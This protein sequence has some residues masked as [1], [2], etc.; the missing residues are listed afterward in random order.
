VVFEGLPPAMRRA[1]YRGAAAF[2]AV[3]VVG[4]ALVAGLQA[5]A[6]GGEATPAPPPTSSPNPSGEPPE[7]AKTPEA[8]LAWVPGGMPEGFAESLTQAPEVAS[9]TVAGADNVWMRRSFDD[10]GEVVDRPPAG[11][12]IPIDATA[13]DPRPFAAFLPQDM[14]PVVLELDELE[15]VLSE[16]SA[17]LRGLGEGGKLEFRRGITVRVSG[18]LPDALMG[19]YELMVGRST[20][21]K[22]GIRH[23]RYAVFLTSEDAP[24]K[25][26][27]LERA[28]RRLIPPGSTYR[29]VEVRA[30]GTTRF[31]RMSDALL[32]P[33][34]LKDRFGEFAARPDAG[35]PGFL[36]VDPGWVNR[37]IKEITVPLLGSIKCHRRFVPLVRGAM[38]ELVRQ[39]LEEL[40]RSYDGCYAARHTLG[41]PSASLSHHSWGIAI[42]I[43]AGDN[44]FGSEP[45]QDKRLVEVME[46]WG[47]IWGGRFIVP[48]GHHFEYIAPP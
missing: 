26:R 20:G 43:N 47:M 31:L 23:E 21:R 28:F 27:Q 32:P 5:L 15:G 38:R 3:L 24:G 35:D 1:L 42:D 39:G 45:T 19:G 10:R 44:P 22:I 7:P 8:Y 37:N 12:M 14:R 48:D 9:I 13:V 17:E 6:G 34:L 18:I 25:E 46:R 29:E 11:Y 41:V 2:L 36:E 4:S 40:V 16:T 33:S 30:P